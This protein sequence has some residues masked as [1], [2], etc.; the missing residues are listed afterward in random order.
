MLRASVLLLACLSLPSFTACG[1]PTWSTESSPVSGSL[2]LI[3][4]A[5]TAEY[6]FVADTSHAGRVR[7][8]VLLP[9]VAVPASEPEPDVNVPVSD[10]EPDPASPRLV[11][12][13][14]S[15]GDAHS[16]VTL[17][18]SGGE[19]SVPCPGETCADDTARLLIRALDDAELGSRGVIVNWSVFA[20]TF[21]SGEAT[22]DDALATLWLT[23]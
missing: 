21:G 4:G 23:E 17:P 2:T 16:L 6:E 14:L 8:V 13:E 1:E 18:G 19:L 9:G 22:P 11:A 15:L 10:A 5:S 7:A 3:D 12:A 20:E